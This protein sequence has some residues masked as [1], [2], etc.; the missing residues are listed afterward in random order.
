MAGDRKP[1]F[2]PLLSHG[3]HD[4]DLAALR[5]LCV[6]RFPDSLTRAPIMDGLEKV[7]AEMNGCGLKM[8]VW[9]DGS[10]LT[11]KINPKDVDFA[12]R[13]EEAEWRAANI[14]Q[15]SIIRWIIETNLL[16]EYRCDS[17]AFVE[18]P[19]GSPGARHGE[20]EWDRAYWLR[21]FGFSRADERKGLAVLRLP[22]LIL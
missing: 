3:F 19:P 14:R 12:A 1:E 21:Q 22:F 2:P 11:A 17:Y 8:E 6:D 7:I 20:W 10:F 5:R 4:V 13:I 16:D 15:K 18:F 9:V